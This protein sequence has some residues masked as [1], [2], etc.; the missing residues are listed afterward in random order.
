[1]VALKKNPFERIQA[2]GGAKSSDNGNSGNYI[3]TINIY[4]DLVEDEKK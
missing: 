1:M 3:Q 2:I 4:R